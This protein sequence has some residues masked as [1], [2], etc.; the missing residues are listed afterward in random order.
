M[1]RQCVQTME[2]FK[3][4][5][6]LKNQFTDLLLIA[7]KLIWR[8]ITGRGQFHLFSLLIHQNLRFWQEADKSNVITR[9]LLQPIAHSLEQGL[10][11]MTSE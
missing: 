1:R 11:G 6:E 10:K 7:S 5:Q 8:V 3:L 2:T 4:G 9:A